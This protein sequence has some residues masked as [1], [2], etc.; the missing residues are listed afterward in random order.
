MTLEIRFLL[1]ASSTM[2]WRTVNSLY[3]TTE[4]SQLC[5]RYASTITLT[6]ASTHTC[7]STYTVCNLSLSHDVK[8]LHNGLAEVLQ[9]LELHLQGLEL[10][11]VPQALV[12]LGLG[13]VLG[14]QVHLVPCHWEEKSCSEDLTHY[15]APASASFTSAKKKR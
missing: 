1:Q 7:N 8:V 4:L 6:Q 2:L 9:P 12:G 14:R 3:L 10:G 5:L 15:T 11:G 13:A